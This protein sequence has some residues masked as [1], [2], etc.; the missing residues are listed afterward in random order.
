M[1][2]AS[3]SDRAIFNPSSIARVRVER[4]L[5]GKNGIRFSL[6]GQWISLYIR[7]GIDT[8]T[9]IYENSERYDGSP[10]ASATTA[11]F[12][13]D[14]FTGLELGQPYST[15]STL[16]L[17]L[18]EK[19]VVPLFNVAALRLDYSRRAT[20]DAINAQLGNNS[21]LGFAAAF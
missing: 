9:T 4:N 15:S 5:D 2:C 6:I 19:L 21:Y 12:S 8:W 1:C 10:V 18:R 20:L 7:T 17:R 16:N 11:T 3:K 14:H 13:R